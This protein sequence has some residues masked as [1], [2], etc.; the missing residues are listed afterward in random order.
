MEPPL[1]VD[2]HPEGAR[3]NR[4]T[5]Q[6]TRRWLLAAL[7]P[8]TGGASFDA[9]ARTFAPLGW[10]RV[11]LAEALASLAAS[12]LVITQDVDG[13][14][15]YGIPEAARASL[16]QERWLEGRLQEAARQHV[17][18]CRDLVG[19]AEEALSCGPGQKRWLERLGLEQANLSA[20]LSFALRSGDLATAALLAS[21]LCAFWELRGP[22]QEAR[23][24]ITEVLSSGPLVVE[25]RAR[26]LDGL[27]RVALRQGDCATARSAFRQAI[28]AA[29]AG[30][31]P[32]ASAR[33]R[34]HL[35]LAELCSG[36]Q[37]LACRVVEE[38]LAELE[39]L[40]S[41]ADIARA[42]STRALIALGQGRLSAGFADLERSIA[43]QV[44]TGDLAGSATSLLYR[45]LAHLRGKDAESVVKDAHQAAQ[46]FSELGDQGG[47]AGC[48]SVAAIATS[49]GRPALSLQLA[50]LSQQLQRASGTVPVPA[51][52]QMA[53][54]APHSSKRAVGS[55]GG[56]LLGRGATL[57]P[58]EALAQACQQG[59]LDDEEPLA[60]QALGAFQVL[61]GGKPVHLPPQVA[62]LVKLVVAGGGQVHVEQAV[63]S[64]WAEVAPKRGKRRLRNVLSKL[65]S[66]AGPLVLREAEALRFGPRVTVDAH[67]FECAARQALSALHG[68]GGTHAIAEALAAHGLYAGELLPEDRYED[69]AI[70][71]RERLSWLHLRLLDATGAAAADA[72]DGATAERCLRAALDIDPTDEGRHLALARY[73]VSSGRLSA[74][75]QVLA[76]ARDLLARLEL[77]ITP[78]VLQLEQILRAPAMSA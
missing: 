49:A 37:D 63:E 74:A 77:P 52:P 61:R 13:T 23:L 42:W 11:D 9:V 48:L 50:G 31:H 10:R 7:Y 26:L 65:S 25:A 28:R 53:G 66:T 46:V 54:T 76:N 12:S 27:G 59:H 18:W 3:Y 58:L 4:A 72:D 78:A 43:L 30:H 15:R 22:L 36:R 55:Q 75:N 62:R 1:E 20:G 29:N 34:S 44:A 21:E 67:R 57:S 40:D 38:A 64:L 45:S 5:A 8:F 2:E 56:Q 14:A 17:A 24:L 68:G 71:A 32:L 41:P 35:G 69:F 60:V 19:G 47:I 16:G 73:L 33:A 39:Q 51:M 6:E 70:V